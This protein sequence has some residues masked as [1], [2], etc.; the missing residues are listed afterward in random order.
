MIRSVRH[1]GLRRL[2]EKD[3]TSGVGAEQLPRVMRVM[4]HLDE[5]TSPQDLGLPGYNL[6]PLRGKLRGFWSIWISGNY[7]LIFR[8]EDGDVYD[9]DL[10]DYH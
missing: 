2:F 6:H 5:A 3:D 1:R 10:V 4:D 7:R 9:V 8:M